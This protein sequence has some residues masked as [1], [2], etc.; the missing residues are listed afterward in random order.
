MSRLRAQLTVSQEEGAG[1]EKLSVW[2]LRSTGNL[3]RL[4][5]SRRL[6]EPALSI[7]ALIVIG[8]KDVVT[9][10]ST[11]EEIQQAGG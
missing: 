1:S 9:A 7:R 8:D 10:Q 11:V 5:P 3:S 2:N 6:I 4:N